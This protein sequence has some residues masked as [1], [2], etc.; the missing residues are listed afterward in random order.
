MKKYGFST[1]RC[2]FGALILSSLSMTAWADCSDVTI[3]NMN[4]QS[5]EVT[6]EI[7]KFILN[8][9]YGCSANIVAGDTVPTITSMAEKGRPDIASEGWIDLLPDIVKTGINE[10]KLIKAAP[11]LAEGGVQGWWIPKYFADAHP[12][13][14][15]FNDIVKH[16]ELFPAP[17]DPSKGAVFNGPQ[18]WGGATVTAQFF[19]AY[20]FDKAGFILVDT[21]SAAGL[22]GSIAKAYAR[23]QA[24]VGYY[25]APTSLMGKYPM[26]KV[27][28]VPHDA[29]EWAR[30]TTV[31]DCPDPKPNSWSSDTV[32]TLVT[33]S[34]AA[35]SPETMTYLNKRSW[36]VATANKLIAWMT[37]NQATG[38][39]GA[40]YFLKNN[41][42]MWSAWVSPEAA[43]KIKAAL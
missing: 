17:E 27:E 43:V 24:W 33:K 7:D 13:I 35:R 37:D 11:V 32:V 23:K 9:G 19:K 6:A 16:P 30:C 22:D 18:G 4:W 21:G 34:Y 42:A 15:T 1:M 41:Q 36:S 38:E 14:R 12:D 26:V 40:K 28:G 5:A 39:E 3:A 29:A 2:G 8:H 25:W 20:G 31:A 10:G